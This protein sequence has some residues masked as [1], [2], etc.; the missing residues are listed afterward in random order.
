LYL[1]AGSVSPAKNAQAGLPAG[2]ELPICGLPRVQMEAAR[3]LGHATIHAR[4][5]RQGVFVVADGLT[6][7]GRRVSRRPVWVRGVAL[8]LLLSAAGV[9]Y[10]SNTRLPRRFHVVVDGRLY[11]SGLVRPG[12]LERLRDSYGIRRVVCL[13]DANAPVTQAERDAALALGIEWHNIPL[14]GDGSS[15]PDERQRLLELLRDPLA[16]PTLV[17]CAAGVNRTGLA[18]ALYR[19]HCQHW[20]LEQVLAE[21]RAHGFEDRTH[22][23]NLRQ[24]LAQEAAAAAVMPRD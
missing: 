1:T 10:W 19:L 2:T 6:A 13:L 14:P 20:P 3:C 24:A 17:H 16:P 7:S 11:R 4:E 9:F 22:H 15:T 12:H 23:E 21:M 18:I 8:L 5:N